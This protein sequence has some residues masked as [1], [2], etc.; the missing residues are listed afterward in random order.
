MG[1]CGRPAQVQGALSL[2]PFTFIQV[3]LILKTNLLPEPWKF[4]P[5]AGLR[6]VDV[7]TAEGLEPHAGAW[8]S[9]LLQSPVASPMLS[10]P[11]ISAFLETQI[12]SSESW[13]CLFAY[14]GDLLIGVFPLIAMRSYGA[15]GLSVICL[16][17]P[18]DLLHTGG[19]DCLT[20]SG[21]EEVI[22][23]FMD[24][25]SLIPR[26]WPLIRIRDIPENS[27][28]MVC[29]NRRGTKMH[30]YKRVSGGENY[31]RIPET[32][33]NYHA[34]LS[35]NFRRQLKRGRKKLEELTD[36]RFLCREETR[37]VE[38]NMRR[39]EEVE[40]AG[41]KGAE[42]SSV[43]ADEKNSRLYAVA[44]ERFSNHGWMEWNFLEIGDKS[45]GA[46]YAVR[47]KRTVFLLKI[48]YDEKYSAC[49]PGNL[50]LEQIIE[51]ACRSGDVDEINCVAECAWHKNWAMKNRRLY[52]L[53]ILPKV[54]VISAVIG[55]LLNSTTFQNIMKRREKQPLPAIT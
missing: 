51:N 8:A 33:E 17:T 36:V 29:L 2:N 46:H 49:S 16:K 4:N 11:Q 27:P 25:L 52:E 15:L 28:S 32:F 3:Y 37:P 30:A 39:F 47:I 21:R 40:D 50:L 35:S 55:S 14:E 53:F 42:S 43:K 20:K 5:P 41:W 7:R 45:I 22:E 31:I 26:A 6:I 54:P 23:V 48:G 34:G 24:Y 13:L 1:A 18:Y 9:L 10:Y 38:E 12:Q 44:A 19:V